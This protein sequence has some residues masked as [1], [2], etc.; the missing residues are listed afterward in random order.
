MAFRFEKAV[1]IASSKHPIFDGTGASL[2]GARWNT[3]GRRIIYMAD[4]FAG[5][6]LEKLVHLNINRMP[7]LESWI[8]CLIPENVP[9]EALDAAALPGW[10]REDQQVSRV[11]GNRWFDEKRSLVL[12]VPSLV[13]HGRSFNLLINQQHS[14]FHRLKPTSPQPVEWDDRLFGKN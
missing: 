10:D 12:A 13:T 11:Y 14:E 9:A 2:F 6:M 3:P 7:R 1:R 4:S 5:A 8:E